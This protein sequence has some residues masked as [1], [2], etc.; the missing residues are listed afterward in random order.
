MRKINGF[1]SVVLIGTLSLIPTA[2]CRAGTDDNV[3]KTETETT[4]SVPQPSAA[5]ILNSEDSSDAQAPRQAAKGSRETGLV[6]VGIRLSTLGAGAEVGVSLGR[7]VNVRGGFNIFQYNRGFNHD[8][9]AYKGQLNLR[10]GE[11]H[12]DWYPFGHG[13]HLTPGLLVYNGNGATA[14]ASVPGGSTFT[15][16][17]TTYLSD[18]TNPVAG[19]GKLDFVKVAPTALFGFGNLV[20]RSRHLAFNFEM[21]AVFQGSARTKLN[22]T[23]NAC[24]PADTNCVDAATDPTVQANVLAEQTKLDNKLSPF[25]YYPVISFGFGYRF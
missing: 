24:T 20:P 7:R 15:L 22:L 17:S 19:A 16:G 4:A 3:P 13:F 10:S 25:K 8:G 12:L 14:T 2:F 6:G 5:R 11:A 23:G 21:G 18:P 9:I 1:C